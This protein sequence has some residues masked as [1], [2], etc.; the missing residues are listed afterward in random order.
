MPHG[1]ETRLYGDSAYIDQKEILNQ[2]APK[3]KDF[4]NKRVSRSTPLTDADKETNRRKSRVCAKVEH[5]SRP[6]KSIYG[7][8]KVRY[9][10]LLK[11]A[12]HA[13]AMPALINLDKWGSPLTGQVRPA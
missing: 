11:N 10:G 5:P 4:T 12:N 8:A 2:L 13:F 9:R 6:F 7:F 1:N 3:A